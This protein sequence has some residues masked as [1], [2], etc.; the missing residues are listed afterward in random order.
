M[1]ILGEGT[2]AYPLKA[3]EL[4]KD[5][6]KKGNPTCMF[7]YAHSLEDPNL[8]NRPDEAKQWFIKATRAGN[9]AANEICKK[10]GWKIT[11]E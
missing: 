11:D 3:I 6:A 9:L 1:F 7:F 5:G 8:A 4:W 2:S 10:R